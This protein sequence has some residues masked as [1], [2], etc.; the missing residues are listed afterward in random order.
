MGS[1]IDSH[2][3]KIFAQ[4][5]IIKLEGFLF[6]KALVSEING[7]PV[8]T[9]DNVPIDFESLYIDFSNYQSVSPVVKDWI[10]NNNLIFFNI[11]DWLKYIIQSNHQIYIDGIAIRDIATLNINHEYLSKCDYFSGDILRRTL[12]AYNNL[13]FR[14]LHDNSCEPSELFF[15]N[16]LS[17]LASE[18]VTGNTDIEIHSKDR[19]VYDIAKC[20]FLMSEFSNLSIKFNQN[21]PYELKGRLNS[22]DRTKILILS[23]YDIDSI[24]LDSNFDKVCI[25]IRMERGL[26]DFDD[27]LSWI[28]SKF[29]NIKYRFDLIS[30]N[31]K[32]S[33]IFCHTV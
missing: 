29:P 6:S 30:S 28:L 25:L 27:V 24:T 15:K 11:A 26:L 32:D 14:A 17:Y 18:F 21:L 4:N 8:Y 10:N 12:S 19:A 23:S 5:K 20:V 1:Y 33:F 7:V 22:V 31:F 16:K 2:I 13:N 9:L 3:K